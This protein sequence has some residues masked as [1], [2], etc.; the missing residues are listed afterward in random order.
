M[1]HE[2]KRSVEVH[3]RDGQA[4]VAP[5]TVTDIH[6]MTLNTSVTASPHDIRLFREKVR[7]SHDLTLKRDFSRE[8]SIITKGITH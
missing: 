8:A 6:S 5:Q 1:K 3:R 4:L 2:L 7:F